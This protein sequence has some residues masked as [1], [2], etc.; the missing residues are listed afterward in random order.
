VVIEILSYKSSI[1]NPLLKLLV[2]AIFVI[3][4]W[5]F[6]QAGKKFGGNVGK[7]ARFLMW[8]GVAATIGAGCRYLGDFF[9]QY[10]W[11]ESTGSLLFAIISVIVAYLVYKKFREIAE[12]FGLAGEK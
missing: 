11:L 3:G 6:Y 7:I 12:A 8:G 4:T 1:L 10:K 5:Y 9:I 2:L